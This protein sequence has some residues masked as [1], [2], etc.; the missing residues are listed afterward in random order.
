MPTIGSIWPFELKLGGR[1]W[2]NYTNLECVGNHDSFQTTLGSIEDA[3]EVDEA[4]GKTS[5]QTG[6][7]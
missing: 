6:G 3:H 5:I 7:F 2:I 4:N 1:W